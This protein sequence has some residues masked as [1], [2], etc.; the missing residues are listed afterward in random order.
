VRTKLNALFKAL[1]QAGVAAHQNYECCQGC[2]CARVASEIG[3]VGAYV[4]Y[5]HQDAE[6]LEPPRHHR[7]GD[8]WRP[9]VYLAY[10]I[11]SAVELP[12]AVEEALR[13]KVG[14][15]IRRLA[16]VVGLAVEWDGTTA[17]RIWVT[18]AA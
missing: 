16:T 4:F 7:A 10:G 9:G 2:G 18:E 5:H 6:D 3:V 15:L 14:E 12:D 8:G 11:V 17:Q 13:L 1:R